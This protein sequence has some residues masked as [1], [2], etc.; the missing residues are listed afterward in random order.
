MKKGYSFIEV[1]IY[2]AVLALIVSLSVA[3]IISSWRGFNKAR[4]NGNIAQSGAF[5]LE[6]ITRDIRLAQSI[7]AESNFGANPGI[8]ALVLSA[9]SSVKYS[10]SNQIIVRQENANPAVNITAGH[11]KIVSLFFWKESSSLPD[12]LSEIVSVEFTMEAGEG[13]IFK[14]R[15]FFGSAVLR[16][17][18]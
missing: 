1:L 14:Q 2:S 18:Y 5:A 4:A 6:L 7:S 16:G 11:T 10:I 15:K 13:V 17:G 9:T 12:I 8:L 3:S